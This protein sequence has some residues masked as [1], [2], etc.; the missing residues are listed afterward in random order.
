MAYT[1]LLR[2][3]VPRHP[4]RALSRLLLSY[5]PGPLA[6]PGSSPILKILRQV[7]AFQDLVCCQVTVDLFRCDL[8][9]V[10]SAIEMTLNVLLLQQ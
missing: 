5:S 2:Q 3:H 10:F 4:P 7:S 8:T 1:V 9:T 6:L